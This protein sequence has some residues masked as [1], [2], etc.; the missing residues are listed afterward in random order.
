M[1]K[2]TLKGNECN[3]CGD[4]P[5]VGSPA[6]AFS[7]IGADLSEQTIGAFSSKNV[8]LSIFPSL[9]TPV[10]ATSIRQFNEKAA[11]LGIPSSSTFPK[12]CLSHS[13]DFAKV[14]ESRT[15]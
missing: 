14:K 9:D 10:C 12:I 11:S 2:I 6:P 1:A 7:L 3:T 5:G 15:W 4:L 13:N 8:V